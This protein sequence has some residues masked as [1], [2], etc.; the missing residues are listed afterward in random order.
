MSG[1][2]GLVVL[3]HKQLCTLGRS[4]CVVS[5]GSEDRFESDDVGDGRGF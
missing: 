2:G 1:D 4:I 5:F 3:I